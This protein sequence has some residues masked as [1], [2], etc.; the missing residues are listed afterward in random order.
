MAWLETLFG[1]VDVGFGL[2]CR[3]V[4]GVLLVALAVA[5]L[6]G[7]L[8]RHLVPRWGWAALMFGACSVALGAGLSTYDAMIAGLTLANAVG[9]CSWPSAQ[10]AAPRRRGGGRRALPCVV[11]G[12]V[13][14]VGPLSRVR[15]TRR[16]W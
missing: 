13:T 9:C 5:Q 12:G 4:G 3:V 15:R 11:D 8:G 16:W 2:Y 14:E 7:W 6:L 1:W 10:E